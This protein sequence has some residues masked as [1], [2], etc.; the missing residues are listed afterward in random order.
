[1]IDCG[2]GSTL[3]LSGDGVNPQTIVY[4]GMSINVGVGGVLQ[5]P[6]YGTH[7]ITAYSA[8]PVANPSLVAAEQL[9][10]FL[11]VELVV[12]IVGLIVGSAIVRGL[13]SK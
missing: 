9:A 6:C 4:D 11:S 2:N 8:V 13:S 10:N 12:F 7:D 3:I 1:V 5:F